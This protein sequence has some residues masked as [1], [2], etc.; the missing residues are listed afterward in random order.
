MGHQFYQ[1]EVEHGGTLTLSR[2][3]HEGSTSFLLTLIDG[4]DSDLPTLELSL[5]ELL[6]ATEAAIRAARVSE[7]K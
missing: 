6:R 7:N 3:E 2:I 5:D 1:M 4:T